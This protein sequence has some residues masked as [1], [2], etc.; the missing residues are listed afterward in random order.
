MK[1]L[2]EIQQCMAEIA[3]LLAKAEVLTAQVES[4]EKSLLVL[5]TARAHIEAAYRVASL[6]IHH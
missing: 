6:Q 2:N 3:S 5:T 1:T 4:G